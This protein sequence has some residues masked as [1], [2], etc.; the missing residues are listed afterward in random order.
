MDIGKR[1]KCTNKPKHFV[2]VIKMLNTNKCLTPDFTI[3]CVYKQRLVVLWRV[4]VLFIEITYQFLSLHINMILWL[5][6]NN[7]PYVYWQ[8]LFCYSKINTAHH[9]R[10]HFFTCWLVLKF[11]TASVLGCFMVEDRVLGLQVEV[12]A[13]WINNWGSG[14]RRRTAGRL[15]W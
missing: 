15:F 6:Q 14:V 5:S 2:K 9:I 8:Y 10:Q 4:P 11:C 12:E 3:K 1:K 13:C 7:V